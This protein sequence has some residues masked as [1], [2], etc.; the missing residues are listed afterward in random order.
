M[1]FKVLVGHNHYIQPGGEDRVFSSEVQLLKDHGHEVIEYIE[2]NRRI[3]SMHPAD[4]ALQTVWS[5]STY[6]RLLGVL[7]AERPDVAHFHNT[8]PLISPSAYS[9]CRKAGVPVVQ[10]LHNPRLVCASANF[11]RDGH[12]CQDCL[13]KTPPW[14]AVVHRCYRHSAI[15]SA[16]VASM[17]TVHRVLQTWPRMV[18]IF[19]VPTEFY[20]KKYIEAGLPGDRIMI[21]PHF[22]DPDPQV[23]DPHSEGEY[24]L[25]VGR[26]DPE[27]GV[28]T[29]LQAWKLL[30]RLPLKICGDGQL[31]ERVLD[32]ARQ[33][34]LVGCVELTGWLPHEQV[35][36]LMKGAKFLVWPSEGYYETFGYVAVESYS[37][38]IPVIASRIGV[39]GE[40]VID[41]ET[42]LH[43]EPGEAADLAQKVQWAW[44]HPAETAEMGRRGRAVYEARYTAERNYPILHG[45][46][47]AAIEHAR[48]RT[49]PVP[50]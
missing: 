9:A 35:I 21:K 4:V 25:F 8:F 43:F 13:G 33:N 30:G 41:G 15:Q 14:P 10:A 46:H 42:G 37:C 32:F 18:D 31:A 36:R 45:I 39:L 6:Q 49:H 50:A 44:D 34:D 48:R 2:D 38:G 23:R 26:L 27:K 7:E 47:E 1:P 17:L 11:Y 29:L 16:V 3:P 24:A 28:E 40:V 20:R 12:L 5:R 22:V 19:V